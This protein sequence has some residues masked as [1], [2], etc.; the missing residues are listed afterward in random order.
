[1]E[2]H[3]HISVPDGATA[4]ASSSHV[5]QK[6]QLLD[7]EGDKWVKSFSCSG[8]WK[9]DPGIQEV[10][11]TVTKCFLIKRLLDCWGFALILNYKEPWSDWI[12]WFGAKAEANPW[13]WPKCRRSHNNVVLYHFLWFSAFWCSAASWSSQLYYCPSF[14]LRPISHC[15]LHNFYP[16]T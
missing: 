11:P 2:S 14:M 5:Q 13:K 6:L 9:L 10:L 12:L 7:V 1:M 4:T 8:C 16:S 15:K 3:T